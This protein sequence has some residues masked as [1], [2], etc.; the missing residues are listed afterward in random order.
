[1]ITLKQVKDG[2]TLD[3]PIYLE[4]KYVIIGIK[5]RVVLATKET[6]EELISTISYY[7]DCEVDI[8][9]HDLYLSNNKKLTNA[10]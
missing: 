7:D 6:I 9:R 10:G 1:M 5:E 3:A 4:K 8:R 2:A